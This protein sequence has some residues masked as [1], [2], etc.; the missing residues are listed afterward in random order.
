MKEIKIISVEENNNPQFIKTKKIV[1]ERE[2]KPAFW[3]AVKQHDSVHIVVNNVSSKKIIMVKQVRIPVLIN[4]DSQNGE[5]Y[6]MCAGIVDKA[7]DLIQIAREEVLEELGYDVPTENIQFIKEIK[8]SVGSAGSSANAYY[9]EVQDE[10]K[11][12]DGGGLHDEDIEVIEISY[13]DIDKFIYGSL[14]T[15][16]IT[17][18]LLMFAKHEKNLK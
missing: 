13:E 5:V 9:V 12:S 7:K 11:V 1:F 10:H 3:E 15:D 2:G 14:H 6:E 17:L 18:F 8:S 16:A 4:D